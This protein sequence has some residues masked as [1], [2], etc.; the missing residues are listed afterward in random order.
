MY[1][2]D[3]LHGTLISSHTI[4]S[5][6]KKKNVAYLF[7]T[8]LGLRCSMDFSLVAASGGY[9]PV[10]VCRLLVA[11]ASLVVEHRLDGQAGFSSCGSQALKHRLNSC[12]IGA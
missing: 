6:F 8:V 1:L 5:F 11:V 12:G 3:E 9:S 2:R 4:S 7:L 10:A